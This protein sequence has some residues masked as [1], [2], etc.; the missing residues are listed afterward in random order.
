MR[1]N[2]ILVGC[3][4]PEI[5]DISLIPTRSEVS[6]FRWVFFF[7]V[8]LGVVR[9]SLPR[10]RE[11]KHRR[12]KW[13]KQLGWWINVFCFG[14][15]SCYLFVGL[16]VLI[17]GCSLFVVVWV[18]AFVVATAAAGGWKSF[19][20][21]MPSH[22]QATANQS[23]ANFIAVKGPELL[24]KYVGE[25]GPKEFTHFLGVCRM[26]ITADCGCGWSENFWSRSERAVRLVFQRARS[27]APCVSAQIEEWSVPIS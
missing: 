23:G 18:V 17:V 7:L 13:L 4:A 11:R 25:P 26:G 19:H 16:F 24:N 6:P 5:D 9:L 1:W 2:S 10:H 8:H 3:W 21:N 22:W 20:F 12:L 14:T 27:S 15:L